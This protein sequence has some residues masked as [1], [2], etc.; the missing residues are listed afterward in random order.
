MV[1]NHKIYGIG[2]I[3]IK[4]TNPG[5]DSGYVYVEWSV[6]GRRY[7]KSCGNADKPQSHQR[8]KDILR[9]ILQDRIETLEAELGRLRAMDLDSHQ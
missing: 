8:A 7:T 3:T 1:T 9:G 5:S 4:R 6:S 2:S